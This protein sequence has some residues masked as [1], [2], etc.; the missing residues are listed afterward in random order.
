MSALQGPTITGLLQIST[1][2]QQQKLK[3]FQLVTS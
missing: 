2:Y 1:H 3:L